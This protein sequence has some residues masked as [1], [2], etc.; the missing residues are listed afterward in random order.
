MFDLRVQRAP[1]N[2]YRL[3]RSATM[4]AMKRFQRPAA[5]AG[6][7]KGDSKYYARSPTTGGDVRFT[8]DASR[9]HR[10]FVPRLRA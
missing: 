7:L 3:A 8:L 5:R 2:D 4:D 9:R 1:L 10:A 6:I